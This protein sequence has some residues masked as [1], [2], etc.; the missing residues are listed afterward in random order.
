MRIFNKEEGW[1]SKVNF[2]DEN[3]V[4]LGYDM[5]Q[6][7]CEQADWFIAKHIH[8]TFPSW[9]NKREGKRPSAPNLN[10]W[11]FDTTFFKEIEGGRW[12]DNRIAV[13]RIVRGNMAKY[14]HLINCHNGYY[15]H[16]FDFKHNDIVIKEGCI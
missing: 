2:V 15:A 16:G 13:F 8:R 1:E 11:Y 3:N 9:F 6:Q 12:G 4:L 7:C 5:A 10:G 14:I